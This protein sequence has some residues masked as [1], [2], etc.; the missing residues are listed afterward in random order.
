MKGGAERSGRDSV[1][2]V[3]RNK[4]LAGAAVLLR[5]TDFGLVSK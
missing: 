2:L 4:D 5:G 1:R 3:T